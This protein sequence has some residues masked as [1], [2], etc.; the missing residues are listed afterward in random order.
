MA[1][2]LGFIS[3]VLVSIATLIIA[4][5]YPEISKI[6][7]AALIL[8]IFFLL[9]GHYVISLPDSTRDADSFESAAWVIAQNGFLNLPEYYKG[10]DSRFISWLIESLTLCLE[11]AC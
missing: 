2:L 11:G 7:F 3:I 10:P 1:D 4:L 6:I 5:R 9:L 8:R